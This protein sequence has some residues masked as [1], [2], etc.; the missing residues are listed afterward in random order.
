MASLRPM[1]TLY[2]FVNTMEFV[3]SVANRAE[4]PLYDNTFG[5]S[6]F[7]PF[8][9]QYSVIVPALWHCFGIAFGISMCVC[10][11]MLYDIW[12]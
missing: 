4:G 1:T 7:F 12:Y 11:A 2:Q 6:V 5:I 3:W 10:V 8:Y 9:D